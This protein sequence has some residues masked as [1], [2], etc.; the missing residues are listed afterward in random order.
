MKNVFSSPKVKTSKKQM[1]L[2]TT[3]VL[4]P[5]QTRCDMVAPP[6]FPRGGQLQEGRAFCWSWSPQPHTHTHAPTLGAWPRGWVLSRSV[7]VRVRVQIAS[8]LLCWLWVPAHPEVSSELHSWVLCPENVLPSSLT[9]HRPFH[10]GPVLFLLS[11]QPS[12]A[13][14]PP[15]C[16][17]FSP[18]ALRALAYS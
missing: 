18:C 7:A 5:F 13:S 3:W 2:V 4:P 16:L 11:L 10:W 12:G 15:S 6:P 8:S 9:T 1:Q 17:L 14:T